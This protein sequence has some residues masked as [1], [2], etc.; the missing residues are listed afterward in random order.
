MIKTLNII[1]FV[2]S[3]LIA[4]VALFGIMTGHYHHVFTM[5]LFTFICVV[6][7]PN[8]NKK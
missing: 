2:I 4:V 6:I 8:K 1:A 3:L 5:V 7:F